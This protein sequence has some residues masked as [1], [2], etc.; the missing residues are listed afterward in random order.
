MSS[1]TSNSDPN[2][3]AAISSVHLICVDSRSNHNKFWQ[4]YVLPDGTVFAK[5]G[6]VNYKGQTHSYACGNTTSA[7][8][9]LQQLVRDKKAKGYTEA[10]IE[11]TESRSLNFEVLGPRAHT[12]K[13]QIQQI[14]QNAALIHK[15]TSIRF[16]AE[17]GQYRTDLGAV[18]PST[19]AFA[20]T[21]LNQIITAQQSQNRY[22]F[23]QAVE[24][25]LR[26]IPLPVG[27]QLNPEA[28]LGTQSQV[29]TQQQVLAALKTGLD[30]ISRLRQQIQQELAAQA[31][32]PV[33][34]SLWM[35]WGETDT[36][37][38]ETEL[39]DTRSDCISWGD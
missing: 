12:I 6:R 30:L 17:K 10:E 35:N 36:V 26:L 4:G 11:Q 32:A 31:V 29:Q 20:R 13:E 16:N 14:E 24:E 37:E 15:Y 3:S 21:A 7:Q 22:A 38:I 34:R 27:M 8:R 19:L 25:Y 2:L 28:L 5:Y 39:S 23:R 9:K 18:T 1:S 33:E